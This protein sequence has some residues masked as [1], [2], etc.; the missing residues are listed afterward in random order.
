M[1]KNIE[2][3]N[4][5]PNANC[6]VQHMTIIICLTYEG[7][8]YNV[9][10]RKLICV[11]FSALQTQRELWPILYGDK[12]YYFKFQLKSCS[13]HDNRNTQCRVAYRGLWNNLV[14]V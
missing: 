9:V 4:K 5:E 3:D 6:N 12:S 2:L 7:F 14:G 8:T 13:N 1:M 11:L 10:T